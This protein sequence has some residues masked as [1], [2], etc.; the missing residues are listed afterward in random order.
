MANRFLNT[1]FFK[2]PF[3]RG[4][5]GSLKT[6]YCFIICDCE[7]SGIWSKDLDIAG[8]Y[9]GFKFTESQFY[10]S[11]VETGKAVD[12]GN[13]KYFFPDFI[14]HQYPKG[15][16]EKNIA[17]NNIIPILLSLN[18]LDENLKPLKRPFEGSKVM[19]MDKVKE[20]VLVIPDKFDFKNALLSYGFDKTLISEWLEV[21][22]K[23]KAVNTETAY[24][25]FITEVEKTNLDKN[26]VLQMCVEK[27]WQG[28]TASWIKESKSELKPAN[29][30]DEGSY[31]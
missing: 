26:K 15:L 2:S 10:K 11:F 25:G 20:K 23:K 3:V 8:V 13:G 5:E 29:L 22:R 27:S 31:S 17:H 9:T 21:R 4:L 12:L 14:E 19:V 28:F 7:P 16:S 6:L 24:K 30:R 1:S 18:L